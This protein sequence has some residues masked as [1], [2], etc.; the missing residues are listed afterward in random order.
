MGSLWGTHVDRGPSL[1]LFVLW[2]LPL[3]WEKGFASSGRCL[4][5]V[6]RS[7]GRGAGLCARFR[8]HLWDPGR[9]GVSDAVLSALR[10]VP[11]QILFRCW[12][13]TQTGCYDKSTFLFPAC[14]LLL[15]LFPDA[16]DQG[17]GPLVEW[18]GWMSGLV[19]RE[20]SG[21][22]DFGNESKSSNR[23]PDCSYQLCC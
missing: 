3:S 1:G 13:W 19:D 8:T 9:P 12:V 21:L 10:I 18:M 14:Q 22:E 23:C 2:R 15:L 6:F 7:I 11:L 4:L 5:G 20:G 16:E 17:G